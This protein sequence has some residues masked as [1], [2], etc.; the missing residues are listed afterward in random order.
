MSALS[1]ENTGNIFASPLGF[2]YSYS[3]P[4]R[5]LSCAPNRELAID[6]V[7]VGTTVVLRIADIAAPGF[8]EQSFFLEAINTLQV[9][10]IGMSLISNLTAT[11]IIG[12]TTW[13][14]GPFD[15]P[16]FFKKPLSGGIGSE[17]RSLFGRKRERTR[18]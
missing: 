18:Y 13:F 11:I 1:A 6:E 8:L 9:S 10:N 3:L 2:S 4:V 5:G 15:I 12:L 7:S 16:G 14:V 17:S